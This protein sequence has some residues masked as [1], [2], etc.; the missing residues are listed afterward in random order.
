M[1]GSYKKPLVRL[2]NICKR[3]GTIEANSN[4]YL[5]I[6]PGQILALLGENGAGKS[7]LMSILAG[8]I[9]PTSGTIEIKG[10]PVVLDSEKKAIEHKIG[11]VYQ[12]FTLVEEMRVWE[13][14]AL[15]KEPGF[16]LNKKRILQE[17]KQLAKQY[18]L[19]VDLEEK[20]FNLSMGEKQR[21]EILKLLAQDSKVLILDEPTSVLTPTET[22]K[23]FAGL[24]NMAKKGTAIVFISHKLEE[25]LAISD[26]IAILRKGKI[27]AK[28]KTNEVASPKELAFKMVGK[29]ILLNVSREAIEPKETVLEVQDLQARKVKKVSFSLRRG[30]ILALVGVAGNGQQE[31]VEIIAGLNFHY[32]GKV[33]ILGRSASEFFKQYR[34][35]NSLAYVPE[36]RLGMAT[37]PNLNLTENFLL[38]TRN[39]FQRGFFLRQK[40]AEKVLW[41]KIEE[42]KIKTPSTKVQAKHLSGGNLQ[43]LVLAREFY[44][45]PKLIIAEQPTQ[46]LDIG[47]T[48]EVFSLLTKAKA[49][50]GILLV[51]GDLNEALTLADR[52]AVIFRGKIVADFSVHDKEQVKQ[53]GFYMAGG[54]KE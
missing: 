25:V 7:T 22:G 43:K 12:H 29:E 30:E 38:T 20:V 36:N 34:W 46:G 16:W 42:F 32:R 3:F 51:S 24:K 10:K 40:E 14:I 8:K 37:C 1:N 28:T 45:R 27:V 6:Y 44:R 5:D 13:N 18:G 54:I 35:T 31:L 19:E 15:G 11:M 50:A 33:T 2:K 53:I 17:I 49:H 21:V 9:L 41:T 47:A 39:G 52:V 4:I 48:N 26:E 23:L